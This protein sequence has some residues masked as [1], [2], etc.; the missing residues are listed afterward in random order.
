MTKYELLTWPEEILGHCDISAERNV[1]PWPTRFEDPIDLPN[2]RK[3][4][5][6]KDA[7]AYIMTLPKAEHAVPNGRP[8]WKP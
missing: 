6:L 2:G 1:V 8:R 7:A 3:L 4:V 5:T